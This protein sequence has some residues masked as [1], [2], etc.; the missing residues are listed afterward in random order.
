[1]RRKVTEPRYLT[2]RKLKICRNSQNCGWEKTMI[3]MA[4]S[5]VDHPR[6]VPEPGLSTI[7][8]M[9]IDQRAAQ[10]TCGSS[11]SQGLVHEPGLLKQPK[12]WYNPQKSPK[13]LYP[14][15]GSALLMCPWNYKKFQKVTEFIHGIFFGFPKMIRSFFEISEKS[16]PVC[17][18][19]MQLLP[20]HHVS[21]T[22][23]FVS[24]VPSMTP[25]QPVDT[26]RTVYFT[27][28]RPEDYH[29]I[30]K[31]HTIQCTH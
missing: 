7:L 3:K 15:I 16:Q 27:C 10:V 31:C 6:S 14:I 8:R 30:S 22:P 11:T 25:K 26:L 12:V 13:R 21:K 17:R 4:G 9:K 1:M 2:P 29:E 19:Y 23:I 20:S 5:P 18:C 24:S 28:F